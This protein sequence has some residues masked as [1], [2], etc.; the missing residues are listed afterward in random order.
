M[1]YRH[2]RQQAIAAVV[3]WF[4][5]RSG[6]VCA[7]STAVSSVAPPSTIYDLEPLGKKPEVEETKP[8]VDWLPI[9]G[10]GARDKGFDLPL[11]LGFAVSYT[12][13][14]QDMEVSDI[15][16]Q[17]RKLNLRLPNADTT[18]HTVVF[19]TDA[20]IFPFLNVYGLIGDTGGVTKP[21][22]V[23]RDGR[24]VQT[25]VEYNRFSYGGG[26]TLAGGYKAF[27]LTLDANYT[28]G[29]LISKKRGKVGDE[30]IQSITFAPRLGML[31]SSGGKLGTGSLWIGGMFLAATSEIHG[32]IDLSDHPLLA[33]LAGTK[34]PT[35]SV[36]V[37]PKDAWNV[38]IG[39]NWEFNKR[40]SITAETGG[41]LDRFHVITAVM[42][43]F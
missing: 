9:W 12:F 38:L 8:L 17:D 24:V 36:Q 4:V 32:Q 3:L 33:Q 25:E 28:T 7:Q 23:L 15:H 6:N 35:Y 29:D 2:L 31:M 13:I 40:W 19:R 16:I 10:K 37:E 43:R 41:I 26:L 18:T 34:G 22:I 1:T 21:A 42:W 27:F 11:P 30:P 5:W 20:W 14:N 39:G